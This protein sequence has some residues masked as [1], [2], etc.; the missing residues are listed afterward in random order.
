MYT[1]NGH[2]FLYLLIALL[3][4][5]LA[6]QADPLNGRSRLYIKA[7]F[8]NQVTSSRTQVFPL[9]TEVTAETGGSMGG[10]GY[11]NW[12]SEKLLVD[13]SLTAIGTE[14]KT[15]VSGGDVSSHTVLVMP[16]LIGLRYYLP[17]SSFSTRWRPYLAVALGPVLGIENKNEVGLQVITESR[18]MATLGSRFGAGVDIIIGRSFML[19]LSGGYHL[20]TDFEE[21]LGGKENYSGPA[22]D[23]SF[24]FL[25]GR[26][27]I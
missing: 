10:L 23:F 18:S 12:L 16:I 2:R 4:L 7:G 22:F 24:S 11:G 19:G 1:Q 14:A 3:L 26:G 21:P 9:N 15:R 27:R 5:S 8:S 13:I 25:F 6:A 20:M 17:E